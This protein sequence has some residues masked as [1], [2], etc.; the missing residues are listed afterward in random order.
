MM[1]LPIACVNLVFLFLLIALPGAKPRM[2]RPLHPLPQWLRQALR[3]LGLLTFAFA[4]F[5]VCVFVWD[6]GWRSFVGAL[7]QTNGWL[8]LGPAL[9]AVVMWICRPRAPSRAPPSSGRKAASSASTM[10]ANSR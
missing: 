6:S 1:S 8:L 7:A 5:S 2:E 3:F 4:I 10:R 9:Y